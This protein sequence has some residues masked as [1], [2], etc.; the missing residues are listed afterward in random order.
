[1]ENISKET[2]AFTLAEI[3]VGLT[4]V[5]IVAI[6]T[7][8]IQK[9]RTDYANK[10]MYY[11]A[12]NNTQSIVNELI[13]NGCDTSKDTGCG[14]SKLLPTHGHE[15]SGPAKDLGFCDKLTDMMNTVGPTDCSQIADD[16]TNFNTTTPNFS[17]TNGMRYFNLGSNPNYIGSIPSY[18]VGTGNDYDN[19]IY[20]AYVDI[21]GADKGKN[22]LNTDIMKFYISRDGLIIL[23]AQDS[24][25]AN[26]TKYITASVNYKDSS[27]QDVLVLPNLSYR[28]AACT[29]DGG[30]GQVVSTALKSA[31]FNYCAGF[32]VNATCAGQKCKVNSKKPGF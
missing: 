7:I 16:S 11:A 3:M 8:G 26:D 21:D 4:I 29:A 24:T 17:T 25:G 9:S 32:E 12:L 5:A 20:T 22:T 27:G 30:K 14:V 1:M 19:E 28:E 18:S 13:S 23:P 10:F 15:D 2:K 31:P 6:T